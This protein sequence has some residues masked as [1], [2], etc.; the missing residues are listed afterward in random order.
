MA[1]LTLTLSAPEVFDVREFRVHERI[2]GLFE[3]EVVAMCASPD[4]DFNLVLGAPA[5]FTIWSD[6]HFRLWDG[7]CQTIRLVEVEPTGLS[8]YVIGVAPTLWLLTQRRNYRIFQ[9]M[10]EPDIVKQLLAGW[11]IAGMF[12]LSEEYK[13]RD[14]RVQYGETDYAFLCRMMED[15]GISF[16]FEPGSTAT[17][18]FSDCPQLG[19]PRVKPIA[20]HNNTSQQTGEFVTRLVL[21]QDVRPGK[22]TLRDYD[23]RKPADYA[24]TASAT[25]ATSPVEPQLERYHYVPGSFL[26]ESDEDDDNTPHADDKGKFRTDEGEGKKSADAALQAERSQGTRCTFETNAF[27]LA[28][29]HL[30]FMF[31][32][33]RLQLNVDAWLVTEVT[34]TGS[35]LGEWTH[36]VNVASAKSAYRPP[37]EAVKPTVNG[38]ESATV[39]GPSGEEIHCDEFGRVRVQFHWDREG[40]RDENSSCWLPVSH[41]WAG[42]GYGMVNLP[43]IG[44]EVIVDFLSGDPDQPVIVGRVY[45]NLQKVPYKLPD[46]KT[47]SGWKSQS[48]GGGSG[49]NEIMFEDSKGKELVNM[50]A[51]KDLQKLVK[52]DESVNIG[53]DRSKS[54]GNDDSL[55][56][57]ND[58]TR[59]VGNNETV[60]IG[61][62]QTLTVGANQDITLPSGNQTE[63]ITGNRTFTLNG[64]LQETINGN[65]TLTQQ[66]DRTDS[67][68]GNW[69]QTHTGDLNATHNGFATLLHEGDLKG[70]HT[71]NADMTHTGNLVKL[72]TG[73]SELTHNGNASITHSGNEVKLHTGPATLLHFGDKSVVHAGNEMHMQLGNKT[74]VR[75]GNASVVQMGPRVQTIVGEES[76][77]STAELKLNG[78][79]ITIEASGVTTILGSLIKLNC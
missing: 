47:Q 48:T 34:H 23:F 3:V 75:L 2:S 17:V 68:T 52:H 69:K 71:G 67:L 59:V 49:Y 33:P 54:V 14:Y 72:H 42:A 53:H 56:V 57:G 43:R 30:M 62:N 35:V 12:R 78:A 27:D 10:S 38:I 29:G 79:T 73:N 11:G 7:I 15:A 20:Y 64:N 74:E 8:T 6:F 50:Q 16:F 22:Y 63:S 25:Q 61:A 21:G 66:G 18:V 55:T 28:P 46:N 19:V 60:T 31:G 37:P 9:Q 40:K 5:Q 4:V 32:H 44:Q 65:S 24:L 58:R 70:T 13:A 76:V 77:T 41:P 45:T 26:Y 51:E 1:N 36:K 39:V